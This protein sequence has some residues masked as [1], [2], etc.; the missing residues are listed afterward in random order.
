MSLLGIKPLRDS[1][2]LK[3]KCGPDVGQRLKL[4]STCSSPTQRTNKLL[5]FYLMCMHVLAQH[6][7]H[8]ERYLPRGDQQYPSP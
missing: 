5:Q 1:R 8:V 3:G 4:F 7:L 2:K 6:A